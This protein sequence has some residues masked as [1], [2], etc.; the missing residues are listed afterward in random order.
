MP[1]PRLVP[2]ALAALVMASI[3][4]PTGTMFGIPFKHA[5]YFA[6]LFAL[7][8]AWM[9]GSI[10]VSAQWLA[11]F[12]LFLAFVLA[13]SLLGFTDAATPPGLVIQES[14]GLFTAISI[15]LLVHLSVSSGQVTPEQFVSYVVWGALG[16]AV[17]KVLI[18]LGLVAHLLSYPVVHQFFLEQTGYRLVSSGI[19]GGLV[20]INLIIYDFLVT[21]LLI[22][23]MV[24]PKSMSGV[25]RVV[26]W[27]FVV[28]GSMCVLFAFSRLL[29]GILAIGLAIGYVFKL[30]WSQKLVVGMLVAGA[31]VAALPWLVGAFDQRFQSVH[32][33]VSDDIRTAQITALLNQWGT[34]PLIG[35]GFGTHA[36]E[37]V[38][39]PLSMY[40][41]E[42]QW[43]GFLSKLGLIG[44]AVLAVMVLMLLRAVMSG[45]LSVER[46]LLG[47]IL[48]AFVLGGFTN[49]YLVS[50]ASG[51]VYSLHLVVAGMLT[52]DRVKSREGAW[53][54]HA[55]RA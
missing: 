2:V 17:W 47:G 4:L 29:F 16:F 25:P 42:V 53:P 49:Q 23:M 24:I 34:S 10:R 9:T 50:S 43:I 39:D 38:R 11:G 1:Q 19:F 36:R 18:V 6:T 27:S 20:R 55:A 26:R 40:S 52:R 22:V 37:L 31:V 48:V 54:W 5:A 12:A 7:L 51:V 21:A 13:F 3:I 15:V 35:S 41:Y 30:T 33:V 8:A 14:T 28:F 32:S 45:G 46:C 44:I